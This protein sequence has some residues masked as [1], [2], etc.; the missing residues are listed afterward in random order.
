MLVKVF[1]HGRASGSSARNPVDYLLDDENHR[2]E[3]RAIMPEL[4]RGDPATVKK[5]IDTV[6]FKQRYTSGVISFA[7][8][9]SAAVSNEI[10]DSLMD[11]FQQMVA[12]GMS[13]DRL[14]WLWVQHREHDRLELHWVVP[15][16]DLETG[17]RFAP[18]FDRADRPRFI[19]WQKYQ[20]LLHG[21]ADPQEPHR[22]RAV[23][24]SRWTPQEGKDNAAELGKFLEQKCVAGELRTRPELVKFLIEEV[25]LKIPR[26]GKDYITVQYGEE[27]GE[28]F[29][30]RGAIFH[31]DYRFESTFAADASTTRK[32]DAADRERRLRELRARLEELI[33]CRSRYL[34]GRIQKAEPRSKRAKKTLERGGLAA[35]GVSGLD[36]PDSSSGLRDDLPSNHLHGF[37]VVPSAGA[38]AHSDEHLDAERQELPDRRRPDVDILPARPYREELHGQDR[39]AHSHAVQA[40]GVEKNAA[41][42]RTGS[43]L[44]E[45]IAATQQRI[46]GTAEA[47]HRAVHGVHGNIQR[48]VR[49][50]AEAVRSGLVAIGRLGRAVR[51]GHG[52]IEELERNSRAYINRRQGLRRV[53]LRRGALGR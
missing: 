38:G 4:L 29:R 17:K 24:T 23:A 5:L 15:N 6:N 20:N 11:E 8:E 41:G 45:C 14:S 30:L 34:S 18:Y 35:D 48:A 32:P 12:P 36:G 37:A 10:R 42:Q 9:E 3:E 46:R 21:L 43:A 33:A 2:H 13:Q 52:V 22:R 44:R 16:I 27:R 47:N 40:E 26:Q 25:G 53:V 50:I 1:P 39:H 28:R 31:E 7:P 51:E 49:F 19:V